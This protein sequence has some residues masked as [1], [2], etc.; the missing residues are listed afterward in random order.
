MGEKDASVSMWNYRLGL[1]DKCGNNERGI[2][3]VALC[4]A[5][6]RPWRFWNDGDWVSWCR[7]YL[8]FENGEEARGGGI[9]PSY[10]NS[11]RPRCRRSHL[12]CHHPC[13]YRS[14][15]SDWNPILSGS[16]FAPYRH[17]SIDIRFNIINRWRAILDISLGVES[18]NPTPT[19]IAMSAAR[20]VKIFSQ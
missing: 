19:C 8:R 15:L 5:I 4:T 17:P 9:I 13:I 14:D 2:S 12:P 20:G 11:T 3:V 16:M 18:N 6:P 1:C 7:S 10:K